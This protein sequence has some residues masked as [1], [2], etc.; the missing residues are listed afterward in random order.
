VQRLKPR[1]STKTYQLRF[2]ILERILENVLFRH[3]PTKLLAEKTSYPAHYQDCWLRNTGIIHYLIS[4]K[5][6]HDLRRCLNVALLQRVHLSEVFIED[7]G[8]IHQCKSDAWRYQHYRFMSLTP[9]QSVWTRCASMG[10]L[11]T[12]NF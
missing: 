12:C 5:N 11:I 8:R 9:V 10:G 6:M 4:T 2:P 1:A 3:L 7:D